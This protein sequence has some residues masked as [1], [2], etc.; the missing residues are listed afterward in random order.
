[1]EIRQGI[2]DDIEFVR[3]LINELNVNRDEMVTTGFVEFP[4]PSVDEFE[5]WVKGNPLFLIAFDGERIGFSL[6]FM[7][8]PDDESD[9]DEI[10]EH[11]KSKY[12]DFVY[13]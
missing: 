12:E 4:V 6:G 8:N 11:L 2:V 7:V 1:M 9:G 13:E 3:A 5:K 10:F